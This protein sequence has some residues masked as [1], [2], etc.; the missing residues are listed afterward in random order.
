MSF[1]EKRRGELYALSQGMVGGFLPVAIVLSYVSLGSLASLAW[2]TLFAG[3]SLGV[4]MLYRGSFHEL[5]D[6]R[7]WKYA[8][9]I[10]L[11]IGILL[12]GFYFTALKITTP[13]NVA[14]MMLFE[15][16]ASFIF[17]KVFRREKASSAHI[18]G[19]FLMV[20]GGGIILFNDFS[21]INAG[22]F[23]VLIGVMFAPV[24][25]FFQQEAR[26]IGS[27]E[28]VLFLRYLLSAPPLFLLAYLFE[29]SWTLNDVSTSLLFLFVN[30]VIIFG[31]S[32]L[33]WIE[34]I[35]R[36]SVS[37]ATA[38]GSVAPFFT[39]V[40]AWMILAQPPTMWQL[41]SLIPLVLGTLLLTDHLRLHKM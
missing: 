19:A 10:A 11:F 27:S 15:V 37:K 35:H 13:G 39:L 4:I 2:S 12:Y 18:L 6:V 31:F 7:L 23:L 28:T 38:L 41:L 16:F 36:I 5:R 20:L 25:N 33:W 17:F 32:K 34:S 1:A 40:F 30:G 29:R 14:I 26:K 21:G 3:I 8:M 24:G 22:D 9:L